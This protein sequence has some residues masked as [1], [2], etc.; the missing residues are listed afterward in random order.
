MTAVVYTWNSTAHCILLECLLP[1]PQ[2]SHIIYFYMINKAKIY[3]EITPACSRNQTNSLKVDVSKRLNFLEAKVLIH[4]GN[5]RVSKRTL[6]R[7]KVQVV[8]I[9]KCC[10]FRQNI[11]E[12][13]LFYTEQEVF[14]I[15]TQVKG[16]CDVNISVKQHFQS[17]LCRVK[18]LSNKS[19]DEKKFPIRKITYT[20][21]NGKYIICKVENIKKRGGGKADI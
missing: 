20:D 17:L 7:E 18:C 12:V 19:L 13:K 3:R 11:K 1:N 6:N 10:S 4:V 2:N 21:P 5:H 9:L 14:F 16:R 15:F 8:F